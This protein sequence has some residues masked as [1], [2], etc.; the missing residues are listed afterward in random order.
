MY[1]HIRGSVGT[2]KSVYN[3][4]LGNSIQNCAQ[5]SN[6]RCGDASNPLMYPLVAARNN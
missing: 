2:L 5:V 1:S 6:V 3:T 4:V